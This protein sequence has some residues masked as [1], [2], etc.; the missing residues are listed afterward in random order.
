VPKV[1]W[2]ASPEC[3]VPSRHGRVF[4]QCYLSLPDRW[5]Y[6]ASTSRIDFG[7]GLIRGERLDLARDLLGARAEVL[8]KHGALL[9]DHKGHDAGIAVFGWVCNERKATDHLT[10]WRDSRKPRW[11]QHIPW[12]GVGNRRFSVLALA[13]A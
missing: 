1:L 9:I 10:F 2:L 5:D 11:G 13:S 8:L 3:K 6:A 7:P 4:V 12:S